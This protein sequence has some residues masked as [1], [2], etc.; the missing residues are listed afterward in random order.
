MTHRDT[1][2]RDRSTW[3]AYL[4]LGFYAYVINGVGPSLPGLQADLGLT[5]TATSLHGTLFAVGFILVGLVGDRVVRRLGRRRAVWLA[6]AAGLG[7]AA[8]L[9]LAPG[10]AVSLPAMLT[11][12]AV[13]GLIIVLSPAILGDLHGERRSAA[14]GEANAVASGFGAVAPLLIGAGI[15]AGFSWRLGFVLPPAILLAIFVVAFRS[16]RVDGETSRPPRTG[17]APTAGGHASRTGAGDPRHED[18]P[19]EDRPGAASA[20]PSPAGRSLTGLPRAYWRHWLTIL[21]VVAVEWCFVYWI[22]AYLRDALGATPA[23]AS[24]SVFAF[25]GGMVVGRTAGARLTFRFRGDRLLLAGLAATAAGFLVFWSALALPIALVGI[26]V[27][28]LGVAM[29]YPLALGLGVSV[30]PGASELATTR[31]ALG[32]GL[33]IAVAPFALGAVADR[34]ELG[35]AYLIVPFLTALAALNVA[36]AGP[37]APRTNGLAERDPSVRAIA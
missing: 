18:R 7:G 3:F 2:V 16:T 28:G 9:A 10:L 35:T 11:I 36:T 20:P 6:M 8:L 22:A 13:G 1:L 32:S 19:H 27:A 21:L 34:L 15:V 31:A 17:T 14:Y 12:G 33:A 29:L 26:V 4:M 23:V 37:G 5:Y 24:A 30:A 25:L